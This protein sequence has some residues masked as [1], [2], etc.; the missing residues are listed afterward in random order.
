MTGTLTLITRVNLFGEHSKSI[1]NPQ[2]FPVFNDLLSDIFHPETP[3]LVS[4]VTIQYYLRKYLAFRPPFP[5]KRVIII[6]EYLLIC[7]I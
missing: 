3:T 2:L 7:L 5:S 1:E 6:I 4:V